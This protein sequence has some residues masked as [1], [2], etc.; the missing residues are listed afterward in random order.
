MRAATEIPLPNSTTPRSRGQDTRRAGTHSAGFGR[1]RTDHGR[2]RCAEGEWTLHRDWPDSPP[3]KN[4]LAVAGAVPHSRKADAQAGARAMSPAPNCRHHQA[5]GGSY[6]PMTGTSWR[7]VAGPVVATAVTMDGGARTRSVSRLSRHFTPGNGCG[8]ARRRT[9]PGPG[10]PQRMLQR[11]SRCLVS[12]RQRIRLRLE[13][14][15]RPES[16]KNGR[17]QRTSRKRV[18]LRRQILRQRHHDDIAM[19]K[20]RGHRP[21]YAGHL[22]TG[23]ERLRPGSMGREIRRTPLDIPGAGTRSLL[24]LERLEVG[25]IPWQAPV[26]E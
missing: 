1:A 14:E 20:R 22:V 8:K 21:D 3:K 7:E 18:A 6:A 13:T 12:D 19:R 25:R 26:E 11:R 2:T 10:L 9:L 5:L 24:T 4:G 16:K 23:Y 17:P 15:A